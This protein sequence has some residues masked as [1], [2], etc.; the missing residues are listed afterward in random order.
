MLHPIKALDHVVSEYRDYLVT[1]FRA[2]DSALR[3]ALERELDRPGFLAQE[4]FFQAHRPFKPGKRWA[5]LAMDARLA[6]VMADRARAHGSQEPELS[7]IHQSE[8]IEHLRGPKASPLVVTTGTGSGKTECFLLPVIQNA[9]EDA[10]RFKRPGLTALLLYPMN[11][12]ANDQLAR[13]EE[14]LEGAGFAGAVTAKKYDRS[15]TE[16]ERDAMRRN[17]PHILLTNYMML[18]YLLVRP[19]DREDIFANHR[20][21]FLVLDE[22]HT[23]RGT[24]GTNIALLVRRVQAHLARAR[25]EWH[26]DVPEADRPRRFPKLI[27]IGTS[28]TI[29]TPDE[30]GM[31]HEEALAKRDEEVRD[32]FAK[33]TGDPRDAIRVLSEELKD[34]EIPAEAAYSPVPL[35]DAPQN[36]NTPESVRIALCGLAGL[37]QNSSLVEAARR[38]RLLW[39]LNRW[40]IRKPMSVSQIIARMKAE[41]PERAGWSDEQVRREVEAG[42]NIGAALPEGTPGALRLRVHCFIRGGWRFHRCLNPQCG[43]LHPMGE[44]ECEC[45]FR[46]APLYL[47]RNCGA[48]Y[49]RFVGDEKAESL[50]PGTD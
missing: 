36:L 48:D 12:L 29:K 49:L 37:P 4:P 40:L 32:F 13:I 17:P 15:T 23:Y 33:L 43:K 11:A 50:R 27:H 26:T 24:L 41:T 19:K 31:S 14:Y 20:C 38:C 21:R 30:K 5:E 9:I 22:V 42:L 39:D 35:T 45:G 34:V 2:K 8:A 7:F 1:E 46:T 47:C 10:T 25:Q 16:A 6:K 44:E 3:A 18:E 28:A